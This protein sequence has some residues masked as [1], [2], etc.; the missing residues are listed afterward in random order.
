[1]VSSGVC[2]GGPPVGVQGAGAGVD[3][4]TEDRDEEDDDEDDGDGVG[5]CGGGNA[6]TFP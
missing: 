1:M 2:I 6:G 4:L 3:E 5:C